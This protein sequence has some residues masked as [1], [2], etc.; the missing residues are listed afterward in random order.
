VPATYATFR[1]T[2]QLF[3]RMSMN[4]D[5]ESNSGTFLIE[6]TETAYI[7][8]NATAKSVIIIDELGRGT[9]NIQG[10]GIAWAYV[11]AAS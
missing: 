7:L 5:L 10:V 4:D 9:S 1:L 8:K 2:D 3:T 11:T 6:M